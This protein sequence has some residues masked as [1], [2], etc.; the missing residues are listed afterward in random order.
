MNAYV[1]DPEQYEKRFR[2]EY[3]RAAHD[4]EVLRRFGTKRL[5]LAAHKTARRVAAA[6]RDGAHLMNMTEH[7]AFCREVESIA[8]VDRRAAFRARLKR[9]GLLEQWDNENA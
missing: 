8:D 4:R 1:Y 2:D 6:K 3:F 7:A 5:R 9:E